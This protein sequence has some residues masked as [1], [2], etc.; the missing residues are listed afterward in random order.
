[1]IPPTYKPKKTFMQLA[2]AEAK[3]ARDRGDY[4]SRL[5]SLLGY[6]VLPKL[7][8][9]ILLLFL[10]VAPASSGSAKRSREELPPEL[11]A[12][13][14]EIKQLLDSARDSAD[15]GDLETALQFAS[16]AQEQSKS[17]DLASDLPIVDLSLASVFIAKGNIDR[18]R[19]LL[20]QAIVGS[21]EPS[22]LVLE[23]QILVSLAALK[24]MGGDRR[25]AFETL[26][27][28]VQKAQT[29]KSLYVQARALGEIGR[30]QLSGGSLA[31]ARISLNGA[32]DI[33]RT[34]HYSLEALHRIYWV[35]LELAESDKNVP[36]AIRNLQDALE[37][38]ERNGN[39]YAAFL[40]KNTLGAAFIYS[41]AIE[42]GLGLLDNPKAQQGG[43]PLLEF[44]RLEMLAF[45]YQGAH[46][47]DKSA[48]TWGL[49]LTK[50]KIAGNQY[51]IGEA[52]QKLGD[53]YRDKKEPETAFGYYETAASSLRVVGNKPALIQVLSSEQAIAALAKRSAQLPQIFE[54]LLTLVSENK[55]Q[56]SDN[57][58]FT[59]YAGMAFFYKNEK[60]WAK[61][62]ESLEKA[63]AIHF[64]VPSD[65][66]QNESF[67]KMLK[68]MWVD[69]ALASGQLQEPATSLLAME[70]AF[71]YA[72]QLKDEN[73]KSIIMNAMVSTAE[74]FGAYGHLQDLCKTNELQR[75]MEVALGLD[76][77][78][79]LNENWRDRWKQQQGLALS[80][81]TKVVE[82][83]GAL[84]DGPKLLTR[85]TGFI[86]PPVSPMRLPIDFALARHYLFNSND[87]HLAQQVLE[88]AVALTESKHLAPS[89]ATVTVYGW[90]ALALSRLGDAKGA[91]QQLEV[92]LQAAKSVGTPEAEKFA[93]AV[94]ASVRLASNSPSAAESTRYWISALGDSPDLRRSLAYS[95]ASGKDFDGAIREMSVAAAMFEKAGR[96]VD[97]AQAD[98]SLAGYRQTK[99]QP[100]YPAAREDLEKALLLFQSLHDEKEQAQVHLL[101]GFLYMAESKTDDARGSLTVAQEL[102]DKLAAWEIQGRS[103]WALAELAEKANDD[104]AAEMYLHASEILSKAGLPD[105]QSQTLTRRAF[106]V[107]NKGN[108]EEAFRL[109]LRARDLAEQSKNNLAGFYVYS[110][111]GRAYESV[112]Q[113]QNAIIA[114]SSARDKAAAEHNIS[115]E[116]YAHLAIVGVSLVLG[117]SPVA[118]E[119]ATAALNEFKALGDEKGELSAY[120]SLIG[121]YAERNSEA[122]DY[123]K[124]ASLYDE[125]S[126]LKGFKSDSLLIQ[127]YLVEMYTQTGRYEEALKTASDTLLQCKA[128]SDDNCVAH[129]HL[130][131]SENYCARGEYQLAKK[132]LDAT[133]PLVRIVHDYYLSGRFL[134]VKARLERDTGRFD[135][136]I[137]DYSGVVQMID[138][139]RQD[140][141]SEEIR[142]VAEQYSYIFDELV[143]TFYQQSKAQPTA[144]GDY[145]GL[146]LRNSEINKA[147]EFDKVWGTQFSAAMRRRLATDLRE[148]EIELQLRKTRL[149][150]ELRAVLAGN[151]NLTRS[152][153]EIRSELTAAD[154]ELDI[155]VS[156]LRTKYP[157]YAA[158]RYPTPLDVRSLP[159][160]D[161]ELFIELRVTDDAIYVWFVTQEGQQSQ[162]PQFYSVP[163]GRAWV[164]S[165][166]EKIKQ[167]ISQ[168]QIAGFNGAAIQELTNSLFPTSV[169]ELLQK[170]KSIIYVPDDALALIPL[171]VLSPTANAEVYPLAGIPTTYYPSAEAMEISRNAQVGG[172]WETELLGIGDPITSQKD[173]RWEATTELFAIGDNTPTQT[174]A[175]VVN[176][177]RSAGISFER[178]P[179]TSAEL[180]GIAKL[181][182]GNGGKTD[183]RVGVEASRR[184]LLQTDL[185]KYRFL[186]FATHGLLPIDSGLREPALLFSFTGNP[187]DMFLELSQILDLPLHSEMVVLSACNTG[188]GKLSKAEGVYNL[189][190]AFMVAGASSVVVSMWEV[191]DNSTAVFMQELYKSILKGEPKNVALMH[192]RLT[193][194][195]QG[196]D[197]PFYWA[198][199]ILMGE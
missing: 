135:D 191:A 184:K 195:R 177:L 112:G 57:L 169:Y 26:N 150:G 72:V 48:E 58:Q 86:S 6:L 84:P 103:L 93:E 116:A 21:T 172:D 166:V 168:A 4:P 102:A 115:L 124:A 157:A 156:A 25:G 137:T 108:T 36:T 79:I 117:E 196:Y 12:S 85:F 49:I 95:L 33:D 32:L 164:R 101:L 161:G 99:Q 88:D 192:A 28:A 159:V 94:S 134:Y 147:Q 87:P 100:D 185:R 62:A 92:C 56:A 52:A 83:I 50:A 138:G 38:A 129:A 197:Q 76:T 144:K 136:A 127:P 188:S 122:K 178:L 35:Y 198:P 53:I 9:C 174:T 171:E 46:L 23:A 71:Q 80:A 96:S 155:F 31:E 65:P 42:R 27:K 142:A 16:K 17:R 44:S 128:A 73:A 199:F 133:V 110:E 41:G 130:S 194:I 145:A 8:L 51:F 20:D 107:R 141:D 143:A 3:R 120:S 151:K 78:E 11:Q 126:R 154:R 173:P 167:N 118:I 189:G 182:E 14:P 139:L 148:K 180:Q 89:Q 176:T 125:A 69:H 114:F 19:E 104:G 190:R 39:T 5:K 18:A 187:T 68:G 64:L 160:R 82:Q 1:M 67:T 97:L 123:N 24:E 186:H 152:A 105:A 163:K 106:I 55:G 170:A 162:I 91:E 22:N 61:E 109:L 146:A 59:I 63:E 34:N 70:Q 111:L 40:A 54:E 81:F 119:N 165:Q 132:E 2:I 158:I 175:S 60:N 90:L 121:V 193:L 37:M 43:S 7:L 74:G 77:L 179:G 15:L 183:V 153:E 29:G 13:D 47:L 45:A 75:C 113:Y 10:L 30:L 131:L 140:S 149:Q 181:V 98:I 66:G